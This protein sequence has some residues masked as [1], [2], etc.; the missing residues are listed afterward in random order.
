MKSRYNINPMHSILFKGPTF[1]WILL[2]S[3]FLPALSNAQDNSSDSTLQSA[4]LASVVQ[5][6][7]VHQPVIQQAQIDEKITNKVIRGKLADWYPQINFAYNYQRFIDLQSSVI[8]GNV[9]RFG[10]DNTSSAQF[11]GT[12]TIF[13]RDV[14]LASSTASTV[15]I[16]AQQ[17]TSRSKIDVAVSVS[18][19]FYDLLATS[20]QVKVNQESI[21]R[22]QRSLKDAM[23]RYNSGVADKTDYKRATILLRNAE[24]SLKANTEVL[25]YKQE[26]LKTLMGYPLN[27]EL[28]VQYDTL[29][30]ENEVSIDT[31]QEINYSEHIDYK[32]LYTQKELQDANV[33]YSMWAFL[34]SLNAFAA[35]NLNYQNNSFGELYNTRYPYSYVGATLTLPIFQGGKR[36]NKIQEQ[37]LTR[38]RIDLSLGNL[39]KNLSTEYTRALASYKS[40]LANYTAQKENVDLAKEVYDIIQLQYR[41]GIRTYLD[42]TIAESDLRTTRINYFNALYLVLSS[43]LDVQR[44]LGQINY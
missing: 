31:L 41:N 13:N 38:K 14:L 32:L 30:M 35:Y 4:T 6:A 15:R 5:Y 3:L 18:K 16:Q 20:Q 42:V 37:K 39:E 33:K 27:R 21:A 12:Q 44:A 25:H 19:A 43:K 24:A 1:R 8:G 10:V 40:N 7:L 11:T 36:L 22:L 34:P 29:Q 17:N 2:T 23:S 9:I 28:P 26:F